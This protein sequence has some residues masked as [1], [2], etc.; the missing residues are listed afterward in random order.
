MKPI[1]PLIYLGEEIHNI[2]KNN[3]VVCLKAYTIT[4]NSEIKTSNLTTQENS[5]EYINV[6]YYDENGEI[7]SNHEVKIIINNITYTRTSND[8]G[9]AVLDVNLK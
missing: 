5:G 3:T 2:S 6:T 4:D 8:D 7:L 1:L 9:I